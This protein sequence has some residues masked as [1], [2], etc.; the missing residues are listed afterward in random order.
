MKVD[1]IS[2]RINNYPTTKRYSLGI[3][4]I[5]YNRKFNN[6]MLFSI[7]IMCFRLGIIILVKR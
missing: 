7:T 3:T 5:T 2:R 4:F 6:N 1:F